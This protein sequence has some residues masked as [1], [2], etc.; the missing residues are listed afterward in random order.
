MADR[1]QRITNN[2]S[3]SSSFQQISQVV[4]YAVGCTVVGGGVGVGEAGM[5]D[6]PSNT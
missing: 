5:D 1:R 2:E 3:G 4:G 6:V